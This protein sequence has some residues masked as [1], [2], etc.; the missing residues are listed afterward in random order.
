MSQQETHRPGMGEQEPLLG[1]PGDA[2]QQ[3][4]LPLYHNLVIGTG[5]IAQVGSWILVAIVWGAVFSNP[6]I[7]F[8]AH[9][10]LNSAAILLFTQGV[11]IL[12][13]THTQKQKKHGTWAHAGLNDLALACGIAGLVV[14]EYNKI[15]HN[16]THFVSPHAIMG[17]ITY[18]LILI[19][20]LVGFT[21]YFVP[22]IYG[23]EE[24][25]KK[26][27]KYHRVSGYII[28]LMLL[29][30]VAAATQT[31]YNKNVLG[32]KL[33]AVLVAAAITLTGVLP[34][35]KMQKFGWLAGQ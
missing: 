29:A 4:G 3:D 18:I 28:F 35:V 11:L 31:G 1:G 24:N 27:Y 33:W 9:P 25:A 6:V 19:Q 23:G 7:L 21:Q 13:P 32:I 12:Q 16:G 2:S 20:A 10:L 22:Q 30:T 15:S 26:L 14:I 5:A 8:S 34:R 17:L